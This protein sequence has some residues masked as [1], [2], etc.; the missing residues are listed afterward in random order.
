[1]TGNITLTNVTG[2]VWVLSSTLYDEAGGTLFYTAGGA[3]TLSE[4]LTTVQLIGGA[5]FAAGQANVLWE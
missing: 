1:M 3:K 2:N 5:N 4:A